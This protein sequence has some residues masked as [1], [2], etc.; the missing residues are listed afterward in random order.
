M[1]NPLFIV[2]YKITPSVHANHYFKLITHSCMFIANFLE[3]R[4]IIADHNFQAPYNSVTIMT[5]EP[6][7]EASFIDLALEIALAIAQ[8]RRQSIVVQNVPTL[9]TE[10][11]RATYYLPTKGDSASIIDL[12]STILSLCVWH[13]DTDWWQRDH[14]P[15]IMLQDY[16]AF[17][18]SK[19]Q[20]WLHTLNRIILR[21]GLIRSYSQL[22][23]LMEL[24]GL[25][26]VC[27]IIASKE[28]E[29]RLIDISFHPIIYEKL[30]SKLPVDV[31]DIHMN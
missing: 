24:V 19:P 5:W 28:S 7:P 31:V 27:E 26:T 3:Q 6:D 1:K 16:I 18:N 8:Y 2:R 9:S 25:V 4:I 10:E 30:E 11:E 13:T 29:I 15:F 23:L 21:R 14:N 20:G 17:R 12:S 22:P